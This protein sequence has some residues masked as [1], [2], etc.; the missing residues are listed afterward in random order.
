MPIVKIDVKTCFLRA[1][2]ILLTLL[3]I[4]LVSACSSE[5]HQLCN[6]RINLEEENSRSLSAEPLKNYTIY[7]KSIYRGSD[8]S[9]A[10]GD[11]S[12]YSYFKKLTTNGI[13]VSQ[14]LWEIQ[15]IFKDT[16]QG[17]TYTPT[18]E[19]LALDLIATSG[20]I[21]I[22]LNT[23]S[24]AVRFSSKIGYVKFSSYELR[25]IPDS[26]TKD[27]ISV[28]VSV[29][30]YDETVSAFSST[31][32]FDLVEDVNSE[33]IFAKENVQLDTGI[34]YAV[35]SVKGTVSN[36]SKTLF[37]DC[38]GFVV[39]SGLTTIITGT[40]NNYDGSVSTPTEIDVNTKGEGNT[41]VPETDLK[42]FDNKENTFIDNAI[43]V[44]PDKGEYTMIPDVD[45]NGKFVASPEKI[46][47]GK[48]TVT[49]DLNGKN[50]INVNESTKSLFKIETGSTLNLINRGKKGAYVG[51]KES[52]DSRAQTSF[53]V[54]GGKLNIA[55]ST[56]KKPIVLKGCP[57]KGIEIG[58]GESR[59][60]PI[61]I[62]IKGGVVNLDGTSDATITIE[63]SVKGIATI[64]NDTTTGSS[65]FKVDIDLKYTHI[66]TE[67]AKDIP[68]YGIFL[69][70]QY[71]TGTIDIYVG[72]PLKNKTIS[73]A[74]SSGSE[75]GYGIYIQ[76]FAGDISI[77]IDGGIIQSTDGYGI[78]IADSCT[79]EITIN[80]NGTVTGSY[81][82]KKQTVDAALYLRG[83][84]YETAENKEYK[85]KE[86]TT[87]SNTN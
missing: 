4:A 85:L 83:T 42:N 78:Y 69:D 59:H 66:N 45:E 32:T 51:T 37:T 63:E 36:T 16:D 19:D 50:M 43:Y 81:K 2:T 61:D 15:A 22:N 11:M 28:S 23:K 7:Y 27:T 20:D 30:K 67:G 73:T 14:G 77:T 5:T 18:N 72:Q 68:N 44:L 10:Y 84:I 12:N 29:Y 34:Y 55:T 76:N 35:V 60:A 75:K 70:G 80:N 86:V 39:R 47:D 82:Y 56:S 6:I 17:D 8:P 33:N 87:Q 57:A 25:S 26:V 41:I 13:L 46:I 53:K 58:N 38:I 31:E 21:Y 65:E 62:T 24:I 54:D 79:G 3:V 74:G 1:L 52:L 40:C 71:K 49:I 48:K 64:E 9:K